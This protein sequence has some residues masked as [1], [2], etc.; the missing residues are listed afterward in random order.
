MQSAGDRG[1]DDAGRQFLRELHTS[2]LLL[3]SICDGCV[4]ALVLLRGALPLQVDRRVV[5]KIVMT[6]L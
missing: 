6:R 5:V 1:S 3:G 2:R 4:V